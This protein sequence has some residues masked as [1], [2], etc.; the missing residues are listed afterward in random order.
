MQ[1][2]AE[3]VD[4][5]ISSLAS[6]SEKRRFER[7]VN[8]IHGESS[9]RQPVQLKVQ[10]T[11]AQHSLA[12]GVDDHCCVLESLVALFPGQRLYR[13][14]EIF[15]DLFCAVERSIDQPDGFRACLRQ[16]VA[17]RTRPAPRTEYDRGARIGTP[18]RLLLP[19]ALDKT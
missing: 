12:R 1:Q 10:R 7:N 15:R 17:N 14:R 4:G 13:T 6:S 8:D 3:S 11:L 18:A 9:P 5:R 19:N 2:H 16:R